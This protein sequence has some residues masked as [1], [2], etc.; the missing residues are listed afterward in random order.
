MLSV[1]LM[2]RLDDVSEDGRVGYVQFL[3]GLGVSIQPGDLEGLSTQIQD[4]SK[5]T[6]LKHK[7]DQ[8]AK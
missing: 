6:E 4:Q 2:S 1:S 7:E 3:L 8:E 5:T